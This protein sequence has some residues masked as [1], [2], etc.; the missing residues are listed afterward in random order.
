MTG[1]RLQHREHARQFVDC[2]HRGSAW[3][4]GFAADVKKIGTVSLHTQRRIDGCIRLEA[5]RFSEGIGRDVENAH[6]ERT[7]SESE[8]ATVSQRNRIAMTEGEHRSR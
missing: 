8:K 4:R 7:V 6:H 5:S 2:G 1:N 3:S